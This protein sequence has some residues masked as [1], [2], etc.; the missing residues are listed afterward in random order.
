MRKLLAFVITVVVLASFG[1]AIGRQFGQTAEI[2]YS[3]IYWLFLFVG[4]AIGMTLL[5]RFG[6]SRSR[7]AWRW[8]SWFLAK[9]I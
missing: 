1:A 2:L 6:P 3:V 5:Y 8:I 4:L 7:V 9:S